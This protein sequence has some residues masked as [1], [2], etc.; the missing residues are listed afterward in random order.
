MIIDL[1]HLEYDL[2]QLFEQFHFILIFVKVYSLEWR[3]I[4]DYTY[5]SCFTRNI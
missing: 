1:T 2:F 3:V 4:Y 5:L